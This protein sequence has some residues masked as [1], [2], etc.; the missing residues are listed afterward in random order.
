MSSP[1]CILRVSMIFWTR[2]FW[3]VAVILNF[4]NYSIITNSY[5]GGLIAGFLFILISII[6]W[7]DILSRGLYPKE[8]KNGRITTAPRMGADNRHTHS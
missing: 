8:N 1:Q 4:T 7:P 5:V 2:F 3:F 6:V